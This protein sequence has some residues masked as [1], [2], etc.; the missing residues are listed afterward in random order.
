MDFR[1]LWGVL[2]VLLE[3]ESFFLQFV[4]KEGEKVSFSWPVI[5]AHTDILFLLISNVVEP[6]SIES[7]PDEEYMTL[8]S[9]SR[10]GVRKNV[11]M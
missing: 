5:Y 2:I 4:Y 9:F 8:N 3:L 6:G 10:G 1:K 7:C 11:G